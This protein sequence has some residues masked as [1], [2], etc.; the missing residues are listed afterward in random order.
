MNGKLAAEWKRILNLFRLFELHIS[1]P[2]KYRANVEL[3]L[4][5]ALLTGV[6]DFTVDLLFSS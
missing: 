5:E 6:R 3:Y 4:A 2:Y 1:R